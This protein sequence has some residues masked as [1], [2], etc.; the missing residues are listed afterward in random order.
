MGG[1]AGSILTSQHLCVTSQNN[2]PR[3]IA[4]LRS[5]HDLGITALTGINVSD[6]V[7]FRGNIPNDTKHLIESL[8]V[9]SLLQYGEWNS[10]STNHEH[11]V[12]TALH[13]GVTDSTTDELLRVIRRMDLP[14]DGV[15]SGKRFALQGSL[16]P[17][18][19]E[20]LISALLANP[21]IERWS[22]DS[23]IEPL[24]VDT[25][26]T[27]TVAVHRVPIDATTTPE[28]LAVINRERG[29]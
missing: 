15:A 14:V 5:A 19:L 1:G 22:V 29:L 16:S 25:Q 10:S 13:P 2:D 7:F 12:E 9:D 24:F 4:L 20:R 23:P 6:L 11:V 27:A 28:Q 17:N 3:S 26:A 21:I 8:L 18:E